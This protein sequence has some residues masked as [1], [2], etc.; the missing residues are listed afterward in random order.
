MAHVNFSVWEESAFS[1]HPSAYLL[2]AGFPDP[3]EVVE[4]W[5]EVTCS[6][7]AISGFK[8]I[9]DDVDA[10]EKRNKFIQMHNVDTRCR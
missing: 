3:P 2:F 4:A 8:D 6:E 1:G 7:E 9:E 10:I 5:P